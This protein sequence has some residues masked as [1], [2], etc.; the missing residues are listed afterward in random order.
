VVASRPEEEITEEEIIEYSKKS[1][2]GYKCPK[3][4]KFIDNIPKN[5]AGKIVKSKLKKLYSS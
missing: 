2:A 1:L 4:V 3:I 5:P